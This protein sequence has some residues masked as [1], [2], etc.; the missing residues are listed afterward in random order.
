MASKE[1]GKVKRKHGAKEERGTPERKKEKGKYFFLVNCK[2][3]TTHIV[4]EH[5]Y[6]NIY[7]HCLPTLKKK[8]KNNQEEEAKKEDAV[9]SYEAWKEKKAESLK[10]KAKEKQEMLLKEQKAIEDK[11]EKRQTAKQVG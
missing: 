1:K 2:Y 7:A 3:R 4:I 9:A 11:E 8:K 10:A 6:F 5:T